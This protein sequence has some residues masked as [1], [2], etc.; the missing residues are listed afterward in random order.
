MLDRHA[1]GRAVRF[2]SWIGVVAAL[3][4]S[5]PASAY[6]WMIRHEYQGC[7]PCHA[8]PSGAGLLT[9]YGRAMG[10]NILRSRYGSPP[11]DEP[12]TYSRFLFGV[13]LPDWLLLGGSL[14]DGVQMMKNPGSPVRAQFLEMETDLK[15]QVTFSRFRA[16]GSLGWMYQGA[17]TAQLTH[18]VDPSSCT[19]FGVGGNPACLGNMVSREHWIGVDLGEDKQWLLRAGRIDLPFGIRFDEHDLLVRTSSIPGGTRTNINDSQQY[20]VA[21]AYS[22][23]RVRG[24]LMAIAGNYLINPDAY[25]ERGYAGF[26]ELSLKQWASLG[27]SSMVTYA[28][29]DFQMSTPHTIRQL[30]GVFSRL[31][32]VRPLVILAEADAYIITSDATTTGGGGTSPGMVGALQADIE[33]TQGLHLVVTGETWLQSNIPA[34]TGLAPAGGSLTQMFGVWTGVL[35]F[36]APHADMRFDFVL[37]TLNGSASYFALPQLHLYL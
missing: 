19:L 28:Q 16:Y 21:A 30:H 27:V 36:F 17:Q 12:A 1:W 35:W 23:E 34:T 26:V 11:P 15:A 29:T 3:L 33:P 37:S 6:P 2:L 25:R 4:W 22:S 24:E 10:E 18:N 13:P 5:R 31:A 9:E 14:R 32:P 20:G 8:D 7:V